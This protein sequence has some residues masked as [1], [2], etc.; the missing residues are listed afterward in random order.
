[1][2]KDRSSGVFCGSFEGL[3]VKA[4]TPVLSSEAYHLVANFDKQNR[5]IKFG[6]LKKRPIGSNFEGRFFISFK[7]PRINHEDGEGSKT[8]RLSEKEHEKHRQKGLCLVCHELG[9]R[10]FECPKGKKRQMIA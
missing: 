2:N 10:S 1:M 5:I 8:I 4:C 7:F 6:Q 3:K 9:Y